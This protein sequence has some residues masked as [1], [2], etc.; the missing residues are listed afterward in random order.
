MSDNDKDKGKEPEAKKS[1]GGAAALIAGVILPA[2]FAGGA[3]FGGAKIAVARMAH[4]AGHEHA[5][6]AH[7]EP[8]GPTLTLEPFILVKTDGQQ[9][10]HPMRV[11]I[12]VEFNAATPQESLASFV[13]R[14]RDAALGYLRE[15]TLE[16]ATNGD[17]VE[18]LRTELLAK[19]REAGAGTAQRVLVTDMVV[20]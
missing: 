20:Q 2:L 4:A 16:D 6:P 12:A 15:M 9:H 17:H 5:E 10:N 18:Q 7:V 13:P 11:A 8:P 14:I 19:F 1:G 3:A